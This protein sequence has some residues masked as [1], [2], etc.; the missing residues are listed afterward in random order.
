MSISTGVFLTD[1]ATADARPGLGAPVLH[2]SPDGLAGGQVTLYLG[3]VL[4][5]SE[6]A[7][8]RAQLL[9]LSRAISSA[10]RLL[11][12][13]EAEAAGPDDDEDD[14]E[15]AAQPAPAADPFAAGREAIRYDQAHPM[16]EPEARMA[17]GDR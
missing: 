2:I 9:A 5:A 7:A 12:V 1:K 11:D 16:T 15:P 3:S 8:A 10:Y 17:W 13:A 14:D 4:A 6:Y